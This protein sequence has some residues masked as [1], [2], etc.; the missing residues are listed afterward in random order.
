MTRATIRAKFPVR[1]RG[2]R[3]ATE[4]PAEPLAP[5]DRPPS[6][7]ARMLALAH[8]VERLIDAGVVADYADAARQLGLTRARLTQV[9]N[10]PLL[11]PEVQGRVISGELNVTER[12]LRAVV[13]EPEWASQVAILDGITDQQSRGKS[14]CRRTPQGTPGRRP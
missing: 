2:P 10:L 6:R 12:A 7:A 4:A 3:R 5:A 9:M 11:D 14:S 1:T 8:Q 13:A